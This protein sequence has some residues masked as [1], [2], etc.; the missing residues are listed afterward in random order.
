MV[1]F[2]VTYSLPSEELIGLLEEL[3]GEIGDVCEDHVE[4]VV[5]TLDCKSKFLEL[6]I[7]EGIEEVL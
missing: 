2:K 4:V 6:S 5:P 1:S 7:L 3:D